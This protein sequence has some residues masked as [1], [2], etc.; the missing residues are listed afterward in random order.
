[1]ADQLI[2]QA[3]ELLEGQIDFEGQRK[4][5]LFTSSLLAGA[6]LIAF[7]IGYIQQDIHLTLWV[8]LLGTLITALLV[9]PPWPFYNQNAQKWLGSSKGGVSRGKG[10]GMGMGIVVDGKK[11]N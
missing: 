4:A 6:G 1:M 10:M 9:V 2:V 8:G 3:R 11:I 5:E 7:I